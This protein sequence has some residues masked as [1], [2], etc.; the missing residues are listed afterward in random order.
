[1]RD[2]SQE[3]NSSLERA[4]FQLSG[5]RE[6][7]ALRFNLLWQD[8]ILISEKIQ[9]LFGKLMRLARIACRDNAGRHRLPIPFRVLLDGTDPRSIHLARLFPLLLPMHSSMWIQNSENIVPHLCRFMQC[10]DPV[11]NAFETII[12]HSGVHL[13]DAVLVLLFESLAF[14]AVRSVIHLSKRQM[15][16]GWASK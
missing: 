10:H 14:F 2:G 3:G 1:M 4:G 7:F 16:R 6:P 13:C 11:G 5:F 8:V 15:L 12:V 9:Q